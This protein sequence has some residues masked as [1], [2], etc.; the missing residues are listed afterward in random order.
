M[1]RTITLSKNATYGLLPSSADARLDATEGSSIVH[2]RSRQEAGGPVVLIG[3][4]L[5]A[6]VRHR[7]QESPAC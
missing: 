3:V 6:G 5:V 4:R 7:N 2:E 1:M